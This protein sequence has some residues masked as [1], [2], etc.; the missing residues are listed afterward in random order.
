MTSPTPTPAPR[1]LHHVTAIAGDPRENLR[2]YRETL[3]QRLVKKSVNQDDPGTY[4]LFY[5]D[6]EGHPGTDLTFFPWP[7]AR[8][9]RPGVGIVE[10]TLLTVPHGSLPSWEERLREARVHVSPIGERFGERTLSFLDPHGLD[11]ALV[12]ADPPFD[13]TAW[14]DSPVPAEHQ[15]RALHGARAPVRDLGPTR[16]FLEGVLGFRHH[17]E[18]EGWHRFVLP[19][20]EGAGGGHL[21]DLREDPQGRRGEW[22]VGTVHH[23]AWTVDDHTHQ[24][25]LR[26]LVAACGRRPSEIIDRFWFRSVYFTEPGGLLFELATAGPGFTVDEAPDA[27]GERLILPPWLEAHRPRIE[28]VLPDLQGVG[29]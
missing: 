24:E 5:A 20:A 26:E 23:L 13:F 29:A 4:H 21:L 6:A 12:E 14:D 15:V 11:V 8:S 10:Q 3:G 7:Q 27:L 25:I 1:G 2:F 22:G 18:E 9:G 16:D 17:G 28:A 19:G